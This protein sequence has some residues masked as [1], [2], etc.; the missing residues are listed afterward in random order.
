[1][2]AQATPDT[3]GWAPF[4]PVDRAMARRMERTAQVP[5]ATEF[6]HVDVQP[7]MAEVRRLRDEGLAATFN[8]IIVAATARGLAAYP[9]VAAQ[10]DY[11]SFKKRVPD[12][13][14]IGVAVASKRG[15][16]VPVVQGAVDA[17]LPELASG[18]A[19]LV[20]TV[21]EGAPD[22]ALFANGHFTITNIGS[23]PIYGGTPLPNTPQIAILGVS[24]AW[25]AP[26]VKDGEIVVGRQCRLTIAIDHR[27]LDGITAAQFLVT[28]KDFV[29]HPERLTGTA[30]EGVQG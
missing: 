1:M 22:A 14:G 19:G 20:E 2:T 11:E 27:A 24:A 13:P 30:R 3:E 6:T 21:R 5:I 26:V 17:T 9:Q 8:T 18:L 15:L 12:S 23:L 4:S 16:V 25:D 29:E 7:A 28:I 10:V